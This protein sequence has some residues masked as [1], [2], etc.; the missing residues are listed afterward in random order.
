VRIISNRNA[1]DHL[2]RRRIYN[3]KSL[4]RFRKHKQ[5][6]ARS[7]SPTRRARAKKRGEQQQGSQCDLHICKRY[8]NVSRKAIVTFPV[9]RASILKE[10]GAQDFRTKYWN[11]IAETERECIT[12]ALS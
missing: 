10:D 12:Q 3:R 8:A 6:V 2:Q 4:I 5:C 1:R 11:Q 9:A 7:L